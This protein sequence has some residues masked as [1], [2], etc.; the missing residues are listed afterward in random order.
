M[1]NISVNEFLSS[2]EAFRQALVRVF[3]GEIVRLTSD[4]IQDSGFP[5]ILAS[6]AH[7]QLP[8]SN[9]SLDADYVLSLNEDFSKTVLTLINV[10]NSY[11]CPI[12]FSSGTNQAS[13]VPT[14]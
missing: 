7:E 5:F 13:L 2:R 12:R 10:S 11:G 8:G 4:R 1:D 14:K 9:I 3:E 6:E